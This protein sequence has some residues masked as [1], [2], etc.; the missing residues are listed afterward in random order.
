MRI[1]ITVMEEPLYIGKMIREI[2]KEFNDEIVG[3]ALV[4]GSMIPAKGNK[5]ANWIAFA[6]ILGLDS[7][8]ISLKLAYY[9]LREF[10]SVFGIKNPQSIKYLSNKYNIDF[11]KFK[12]LQTA[13]NLNTIKKLKPDII[14]NQTN[15]ILKKE[16]INIPSIGIINRHAGLLPKYRGL[17]APFWALKNREVK[18]GVSIHFVDEKIDNGEIIIQKKIHIKRFDSFLELLDR[19]FEETP[20]AMI[21]AITKLKNPNFKKELIPN[22]NRKSTYYGQPTIRDAIDFKRRFYAK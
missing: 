12:K 18:S 1:F 14:I 19:I 10:L 8:K 17:F 5:I 7:I 3:I 6:L 21:Q 16:I 22:N 13:E 15:A 20:N 2:I 9:K 11:F 4:S